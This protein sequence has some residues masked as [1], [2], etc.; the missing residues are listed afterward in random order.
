VP[1]DPRPRLGANLLGADGEDAALAV[2]IGR[3]YRVVARN[4]RCGLGELD[5]VLA[6]DDVLVVCEVK[7]RR[8]SAF[9]G[10]F[11]AVTGRKRA[12]VRSV[13][14]AFVQASGAQASAVRFDVASVS[15]GPRGAEVELF[16]DAF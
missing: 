11:D 7:T 10:G 16:E 15:L 6:R 4:W 12:K 2:Y 9:G 13:T 3:G 1:E 8:G 14:E 5:I